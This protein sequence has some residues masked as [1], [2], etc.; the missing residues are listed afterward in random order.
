MNKR[1]QVEH[2]VTWNDY[3]FGLGRTTNQNSSGERREFSQ[4][5]LKIHGHAI[6][7]RGYM[8]KTQTISH[9]ALMS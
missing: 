2:P 8:Q 7:L 6:E 4:E 1:L 9:Q 3:K 5:D